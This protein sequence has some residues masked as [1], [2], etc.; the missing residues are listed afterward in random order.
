MAGD[1][2]S[3]DAAMLKLSKKVDYG[4]ILL[5]RM[6]R[7]PAA[8]SARELAGQFR[9]PAPMVA[10]ILKEL[11]AAGI[12]VSTRGAQGGYELARDA[13]QISLADIVN[14][15]EGPISLVDCTSEEVT[16]RYT[17]HCPTQEPIQN[18]HR[19]FHEF[20]TAYKLDEIIGTRGEAP[21]N[22]QLG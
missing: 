9:L 1:G 17:D 6:R 16:C 4:L 20:M 18:V 8:A 15:L 21:F 13:S 5:S 10:N 2:E 7:Q 3:G 19:R 14:A 12:L 22:F 11:A